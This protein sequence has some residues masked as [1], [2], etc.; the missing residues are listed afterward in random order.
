M[1]RGAISI[2]LLTKS[3]L[4]STEKKPRKPFSI[5]REVLIKNLLK[6]LWVHFEK[7][8][9]F[10]SI[11]DAA[12]QES[13]SNHQLR[14][15]KNKNNHNYN[16]ISSF[17][18]SMTSQVRDMNHR[19]KIMFMSKEKSS[20]VV[21]KQVYSAHTQ[22]KQ[23]AIVQ[24]CKKDLEKNHMK[25][26]QVNQIDEDLKKEIDNQKWVMQRKG[27][28]NLKGDTKKKEIQ[29]NRELTELNMND[30]CTSSV[31]NVLDNMFNMGWRLNS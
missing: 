23:N 12:K 7:T 16:V 27:K 15:G 31:V 14:T 20:N 5:Q 17:Q 22:V 1:N 3:K 4:Q 18:R 6:A 30:T 25:H 10:L 24:N 8:G 19:M 9:Q 26:T 2:A 28:L 29:K 11:K 13:I 21:E